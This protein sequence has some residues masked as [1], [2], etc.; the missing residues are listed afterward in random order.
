MSREEGA[1]AWA[2]E[3]LLNAV[4][5]DELK[6]FIEECPMPEVAPNILTEEYFVSLETVQQPCNPVEAL[7]AQLSRRP[8]VAAIIGDM[9]GAEWS[10]HDYLDSD[11]PKGYHTDCNRRLVDDSTVRTNPHWSSVIYL[12]DEGGPTVVWQDNEFVICQ[13][14]RGRYFIFQGDLPHGVLY[15]QAPTN[16]D[17]IIL[18]ITWWRIGDEATGSRE[19]PPGPLG[20]LQHVENDSAEEEAHGVSSSCCLTPLLATPISVP[21][22]AHLAQWRMQRLPMDLHPARNDDKPPVHVA[23]RYIDP[24]YNADWCPAVSH[25][26]QST[27]IGSRVDADWLTQVG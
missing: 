17:R 18:S 23:V 15:A 3:D 8:D 1:F 6:A 14:K 24:D 13:P 4:Q 11:E 20:S 16:R 25:A 10:W 26:L 9:A 12:T 5:V 19:R 21:F 7:V 22:S 2:A 27:R